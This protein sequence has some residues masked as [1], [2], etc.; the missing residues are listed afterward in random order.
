[1]VDPQAEP[2]AEETLENLVR[3]RAKFLAAYQNDAYAARYQ[4]RVARV[5]GAEAKRALGSGELS[6]AVARNLFKLMAYKDEY[7]VARLYTN[8]SFQR[9]LATT[10]EGDLR[11]EYHLAPPVLVRKDKTSGEA[12]KMSFGPWMIHGFKVLA[13]LRFLRGSA[14]DPFGYLRE[15][16]DERQAIA[17]YEELCDELAVCLSAANYALACALASL[18]EKIR[19]YGYVKARAMA[20]VGVERKGLLQRWRAAT[21]PLQSAAE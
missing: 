14:L 17:D 9:Q 19:G 10:F 13:A 3:R 16:R 1:L 7:E 12:R 5:A 11:L 21:E 8:G 6:R 18:P 4:E 2:A 20:A 15:R